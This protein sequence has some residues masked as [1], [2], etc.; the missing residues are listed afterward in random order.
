MYIATPCPPCLPLL[1]LTYIT[2]APLGTPYPVNLLAHTAS[3]H[4][5]HLAAG[6]MC[7]L[8]LNCRAIRGE[9]RGGSLLYLKLFLCHGGSAISLFPTGLGRGNGMGG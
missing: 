5:P 2:L 9:I 1:P 7:V 4:L 6:Q 3:D 8:G